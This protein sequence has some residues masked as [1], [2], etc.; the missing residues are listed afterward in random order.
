MRVLGGGDSRLSVPIGL[1]QRA[2]ALGRS[3][4]RVC[5]REVCS[6]PRATWGGVGGAG[7][8]SSVGGGIG[9]L[10]VPAGVR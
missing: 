7:T 6:V 10:S 3:G 9:R 1:A 2:R 4:R 5:D 8:C